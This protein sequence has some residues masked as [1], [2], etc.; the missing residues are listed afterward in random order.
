M[1]SK[2]KFNFLNIHLIFCSI[3]QFAA[4]GCLKNHVHKKYHRLLLNGL[5]N[6]QI[7]LGKSTS[8]NSMANKNASMKILNGPEMSRDTNESDYTVSESTL[9]C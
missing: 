4:M 5:P 7:L 6:L 1:I 2:Y 3:G 9:H 8:E